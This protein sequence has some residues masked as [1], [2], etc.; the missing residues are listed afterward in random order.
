MSRLVFLLAGLLFATAAHAAD[1]QQR[2]YK[3]DSIVASVKGRTLTIE[4]KGAV[5]SGGWRDGRLHRIHAAD[6]NTLAVE[7]LATPPPPEMTVIEGLVPVSARLKLPAP[8]N[9]GAVRA[10]AEANEVTSQILH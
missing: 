4:A 10:V 5:Q 8:R 6:P 2:V 3:V 1:K 7:F 9:V